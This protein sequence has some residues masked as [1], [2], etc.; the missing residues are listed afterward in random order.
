SSC[1]VRRPILPP[2]GSPDV[3]RLEMMVADELARLVEPFPGGD[4]LAAPLLCG[5][6]GLG[7]LEHLLLVRAGNDDYAVRIAAEQIAGLHAG[8]ADRDGHL[9]GIDLHSILAGAHR[10]APAVD[11]IAELE[12]QMRIAVRSVDDGPGQT[13]AMRERRQNV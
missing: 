5:L 2:G 7:D 3:S 10:V 12:T 1:F 9:L 6:D 13:L 4:Q 8:L 11:R